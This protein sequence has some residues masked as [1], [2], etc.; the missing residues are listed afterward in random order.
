MYTYI[1]HYGNELITLL[2]SEKC[3][4]ENNYPIGEDTRAGKRRVR[5]I[6]VS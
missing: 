5:G 3:Y 6:D 2:G 1:K 4:M